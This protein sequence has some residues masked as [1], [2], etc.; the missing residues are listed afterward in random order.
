MIVLHDPRM[1][2]QQLDHRGRVLATTY[3]KEVDS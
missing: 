3:R 2:C 1:D